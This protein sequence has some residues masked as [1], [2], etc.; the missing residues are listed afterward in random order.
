MENDLKERLAEAYR[1]HRS[2]D[3]DQARRLYREILSLDPQQP[4]ANNLMGLLCLQCKEP[5]KAIRHI[6]RALQSAPGEARSYANLG[7]AY[8]DLGRMQEAADAFSEAVR[9]QPDNDEYL[10][11][12]GNALRL[13][14]NPMKAVTVL[15]AALRKFSGNPGLCHNLALAQNDA[16]AVLN[17]SGE[18]AEA[19]VHFQRALEL[20][21]D[22]AQALL[23]LGLTLEQ[24]GEAEGAEHHYRAAIRAKPDLADAHF[25]LAHLRG[26][27]ASADEIN[28][29]KKLADGP[30]TPLNDRIK[31]AFALG[32]ALES[33]QDYHAAF[34][35]MEHAHRLQSSRVRYDPAAERKRFRRI[36][37]LFTQE[38]L[39]QGPFGSEDSRL[40]FICGM[41]RSGTTLTEQVLS[42]HQDVFGAGDTTALARAANNLSTAPQLPFPA[43]LQSLRAETLQRVAESVLQ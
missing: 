36:K 27:K 39:E 16:G 28:T 7:V 14:G 1:V 17:R 25:Q 18:P 38:R 20:K 3:A 12:H 4:D 13:A 23:N 37:E 11:S 43:G 26:R 42:S 24:V 15:E 22:H 10:S 31:L 8:K 9:L 2:G 32:I 34:Q 21:P 30:G 5:V 35:H 40:I 29:M 6:K 33:T 41:P 19:I